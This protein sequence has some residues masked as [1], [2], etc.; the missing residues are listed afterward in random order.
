M[1][2][3][4][5]AVRPED[6]SFLLSL[7]SVNLARNR[8]NEAALMLDRVERRPVLTAAQ[9]QQLR[10]LHLRLQAAENTSTGAVEPTTSPQ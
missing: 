4:A 6:P 9:Q 2:E 1:L 3:R 8:F 10:E 7:A 5:L